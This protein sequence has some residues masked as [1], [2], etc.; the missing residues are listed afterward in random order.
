M[1]AEVN[2]QERKKEATIEETVHNGLARDETADKEKEADVGK[3]ALGEYGREGGMKPEPAQ[4]HLQAEQ[5]PEEELELDEAVRQS[6][7]ASTAPPSDQAPQRD[8]AP[9]TLYVRLVFQIVDPN[10]SD[11]AASVAAEAA[12]AKAAAQAGAAMSRVTDPPAAE[13]DQPEAKP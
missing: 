4:P 9:S 13:A 5:R 3:R 2:G 7:S 8:Q 12:G 6:Q 10:G 11:V 1:P